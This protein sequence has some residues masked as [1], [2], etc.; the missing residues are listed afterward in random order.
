[1]PYQ[2]I[3]LGGYAQRTVIPVLGY[4]FIPSANFMSFLQ[5]K[6]VHRNNSRLFLYDMK[7]N[8]HYQSEE[9]EKEGTFSISSSTLAVYNDRLKIP[10]L[11][12][13][14]AQE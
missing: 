13:D 10:L 3:I 4:K 5:P 14:K 11:T 8:L 12:F 6:Y 7:K 2:H 1:M 9:P